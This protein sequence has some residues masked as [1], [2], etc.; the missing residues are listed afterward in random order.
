MRIIRTA[1][2][3]E[4]AAVKV[5]GRFGKSFHGERGV[6]TG[7]VVS[8]RLFCSI[9]FLTQYFDRW[10]RNG[11]ATTGRASHWPPCSTQTTGCW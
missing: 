4:R 8:P 1:Y 10:R 9:W 7:D 6:K 2:A 5:N 11:N 3:Q